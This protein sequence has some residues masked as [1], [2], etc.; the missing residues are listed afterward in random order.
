MEIDHEQRNARRLLRGRRPRPTREHSG[1]RNCASADR[2]RIDRDVF[3]LFTGCAIVPARS[4]ELARCSMFDA[5]PSTRLPSLC[6]PGESRCQAG[7]SPF[8]RSMMPPAPSI[9]QRFLRRCASDWICKERV[10]RFEKLYLKLELLQPIGSFKI[11]GAYNVVRQ[12]SAGEL[13][14]GVWTVSAGNA[15]QGVALRRAPGRRALRR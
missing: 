5:H 11:R 10:T 3:V 8:L 6:P 1:Q 2:G 12:L 4:A 14:D 7:V 13:R 9:A 15:A